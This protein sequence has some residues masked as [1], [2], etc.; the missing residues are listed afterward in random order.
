[1]FCA[2]K[3]LNVA[4]SL[5]M[6][7]P[8]LT[9]FIQEHADVYRPTTLNG[10]MVVIDGNR[11]CHYL[12]EGIDWKSG[13]QYPQFRGVILDFFKSLSKNKVTPV[14]I[15]DGIDFRH[16]LKRTKLRRKMQMQQDVCREL[17]SPGA[18][19]LYTPSATGKAYARVL[20]VL[21]LQTFSQTLQEQPAIK[22][23]LTNGE[24]DLAIAL[25]A[26]LYN[27]PVLSEDSDYYVFELNVGYIPFSSLKIKSKPEAQIQGSLYIRENFCRKYGISSDLCVAIPTIWQRLHPVA[28]G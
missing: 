26:N 23:L 9:Q 27:C 17:S 18:R 13:G 5:V 24:S 14:V 19:G 20:P 6:G 8:R 2:Y 25:L 12:Y 11:L 16:D 10:G 22:V 7:I 15:I 3:G 21:A 1:M 4:C 28:Y